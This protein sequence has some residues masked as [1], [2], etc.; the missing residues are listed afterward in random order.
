MGKT[1]WAALWMGA[2]QIE[3]KDDISVPEPGPDEVLV[4]VA[5]GGICGTDLM[6]YLGKHPRAKAPL[7]MCHEF[8]GTIEEAPEGTWAK[9]T[10]VAINPLLTCGE[11][12]ACRTGRAYVCERLGLVGIDRDGGFAQY[13]SV[14]AH[15]I[16]V[17][18]STLRLVE[19]ALIEPLAVAVHA[20]RHSDLK[21]GDVTAVLGA[22]PVGILT[23]QMARLA[24]ARRVFV[25]EISPRRLAIAQKL[26]FDV[27][28][29]R[30]QD[31]VEIVRIETDGVGVPVVFETA[32]VQATV[33]QAG[34]MAMI[35]GQILQVGMPK[36]PVTIDLTPLLFREI[37]RAP[38]RVYREQDFDLAI[39]LAASGALD[40]STPV[41]H[42]L[43][44]SELERGLH[45]A[46]EAK[47]G[48]KILIAPGA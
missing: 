18:P 14:P 37:R 1:M 24:G 19:A 39:T 13:V 7:I 46:H 11:C 29:S 21:V 2:E 16:R 5:Y 12:Y 22:G 10:P 31:A 48:C 41:T 25:S 40:L 17:L 27:I 47:D 32:G 38:I 26:G 6:I 36:E 15:T 35:T 4:K 23:A 3:F 28:D 30:K 8:V 42:I 33:N 9:G 44:L 45:I 43:P 20:V 34:Q